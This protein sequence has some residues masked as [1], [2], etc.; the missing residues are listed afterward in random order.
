MRFDL[1]DLAFTTPSEEGLVDE[2]LEFRIPDLLAAC[3][4]ACFDFTV[5][6]REGA[7]L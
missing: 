6:V 3:L 7:I 5:L 4:E 1:A 2:V